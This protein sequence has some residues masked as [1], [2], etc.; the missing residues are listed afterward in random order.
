MKRELIP[1]D[2]FL[3]KAYHLWA[4]QWLV[5]T[6]GDFAEGRF[7]AMTVGWGSVGRMENHHG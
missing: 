7:N 1:F 5:M 6:T 4:K 2:D 3:V